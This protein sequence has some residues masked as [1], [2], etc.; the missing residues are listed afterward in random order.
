MM[1][2]FY[3]FVNKTTYFHYYNQKIVIQFTKSQ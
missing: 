2:C 3:C 1:D